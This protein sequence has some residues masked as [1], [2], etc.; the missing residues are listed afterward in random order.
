MNINSKALLK[1]VASSPIHERG[2]ITLYVVD[3]EREAK[4]G[5]WGLWHSSLAIV[6]GEDSEQVATR[7]MVLW[8]EFLGVP[9]Q[10]IRRNKE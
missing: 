3:E 8:N 5:G 2:A 1:S 6:E 9:T 7:L 4:Y 10:D